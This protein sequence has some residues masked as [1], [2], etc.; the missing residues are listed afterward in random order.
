MKSFSA[1]LKAFIKR[2]WSYYEL[3]ADQGFDAFI[4]QCI[5]VVNAKEESARGHFQ[6]AG[7]KIEEGSEN[8]GI[9]QLN[10][11]K[12]HM[13]P[14][15]ASS[16]SGEHIYTMWVPCISYLHPFCMLHVYPDMGSIQQQNFWVANT[17]QDR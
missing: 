11:G 14:H 7:L 6:H 1:E 3:D 8:L 5:D 4:E 9:V 15:V 2:N 17:F 10:E 13:C 12:I 16:C